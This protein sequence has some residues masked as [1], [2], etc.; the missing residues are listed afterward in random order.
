MHQATGQRR[1]RYWLPWLVLSVFVSISYFL[2]QN[3]PKITRQSQ[4]KIPA[5]SVQVQALQPQD[6]QVALSWPAQVQAAQQTRLKAQVGGRI[7]AVS[8]NWH[9]GAQVE[10][11]E[12]L[13]HLETSEYALALAQ[14]Q[15]AWARARQTLDELKAQSEDAQAGWENLGRSGIAP[16][17][18]RLQLQIETAQAELVAAKA[19]VEVAQ[20][21]LERTQIR[22]PYAGRLYEVTV[23]LADTL[24]TQEVLASLYR[25]DKMRVH[26]NLRLQEETW[27]PEAGTVW[28]VRD[29]DT[30][31]T[32][33]AHLQYIEPQI[34]PNTQT[35]QAVLILTQAANPQVPLPRL[36]QQVQVQVASRPLQQV[37]VVPSAYLH[38]D[39]FIYLVREQVLIKHPIQVLWKGPQEAVIADL[40][41]Y[42]TQ[43]TPGDLMVVS[44]L[45]QVTTGMPV[46]LATTDV[47]RGNQP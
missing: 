3:P 43:L 40:A 45:G 47:E 9:S 5:V 1:K 25:T 12:V 19:A 38:E 20:L 8:E 4:A 30:Q 23:D 22:A 46:Q 32:W 39:T 42:Q 15:A 44:P 24:S 13:L 21:N 27:L 28:Q 34:E 6:Y 35:L 17:R 33:S 7:V 14:A 36:Q 29:P 37:W 26:F 11:G 2:L 16:K 31:H 10:A 18:I 41:T